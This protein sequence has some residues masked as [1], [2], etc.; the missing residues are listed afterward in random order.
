MADILR[1]TT[2]MT[3]QDAASKVRPTSQEPASTNIQNLVNPNRVPSN[4]PKGLYNEQDKNKFSPNLKSNYDSFMQKIAKAPS[5]S[6]EAAKLFFTRY[7]SIVNSGMGDGIAAEM[8]KYLELMKVSD[9]ELL[10][11]LKGMQGSAVKFTG[12]FFDILR[13]IMNNKNIS[14]DAKQLILEFLKRYDA[15]TANNHTLENIISNLNNIADRMMKSSAEQLRQMMSALDTTVAKGD[16]NENLSQLRDNI[17]PFLARYISQTKDFGSVRDNISLFILNLTK[18]EI[19]SRE[20]F[21]NALNSLLG[22]PEVSSKVTNSMV[23]ELADNIFANIKGD[24]SIMLQDQLVHILTKGLDGQAGYQNT[25]VFQN[26]LQSALLNES[27]Y[28]PLLHLM[29]PADYHGRHMFSEIWVDPDSKEGNENEAGKAVKLFVKFDIKDLGFFEM[30]MLVQNGKVDMQLFYP[31][32]LETMKG[33]IKEGIFTII[34]RN[35]LKFRSYMADRCVQPKPISD[36]FHKL[37]EGR[38]MVNVTV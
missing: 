35:D 38:N 7:G 33:Q 29:L 1:V 19:G 25:Q 32:H 22:I 37:F 10:A 8:S 26:I 9:A 16:V 12:E 5:M 18:Y 3:G 11:L 17:I 4:D 27:V 30:I 23:A 2:P 28:M 20:G 13:N 6:A 36:V 34:E 14:F 31:E 15:I 24:Q 21:S